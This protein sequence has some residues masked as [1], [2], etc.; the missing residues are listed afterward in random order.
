MDEGII[1]LPIKPLPVSSWTRLSTD[2]KHLTHLLDLFWTWENT[3][4]RAIHRDTFR[5]AL[6]AT[7]PA[8]TQNDRGTFQP[9]SSFLVNAM[10]AVGCVRKVFYFETEWL[11]VGGRC[12]QREGETLQTLK[13]LCHAGASTP[14]KLLD[15]MIRVR[16][17]TRRA[18]H[19]SRLQHCSGC[20]RETLVT[21]PWL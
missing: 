5:D 4:S 18:L 1:N 3:V 21:V 17:T 13:T 2:D 9:C 12:T 15:F 16:K 7:F 19:L 6:M 10:L 20:M 8:N 11:I 14:M